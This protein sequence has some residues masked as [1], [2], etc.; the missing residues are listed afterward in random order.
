M[1]YAYTDFLDHPGFVQT[2]LRSIT[3]WG[4]KDYWFPEIR[5]VGGAGLMFVLVLYPYVYLLA[6]SAFLRESAT[7]NLAARSLGRGAT[8][9]FWSVSLPIARPAIA[10]GV[11][12]AVMETIADF[13]TVNYFGIQ[14]F[15]TGIYT[16]WFSFA[17]KGGAA[18]LAFCLLIFALF[19]A[20][21]EQV[22]S[23]LLYTSPSPRD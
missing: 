2:F 16:S 20:V 22:Q 12:L 7:A 19:L 18:Q 21:L 6:R 8:G 23:C 4:P 1:G 13:G 15:A 11:L 5:S 14:T 17:D 3:G 9:A 10:G